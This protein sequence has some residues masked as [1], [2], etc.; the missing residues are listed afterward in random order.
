MATIKD[1]ADKAGVSTA[2]VSR[3]LN[4]DVTLSVSDETK[5][6]VFEV[7]EELSYEKHTIRKR[8]ATKIALINWRTEEEELD[9]IYYMSIRLG[10]EKRCD[11]LNIGIVRFFKNSMEALSKEDIQ[12]MIVIG[13]YSK[14]E[15]AYFKDIT[16]NIVFVDSVVYDEDHFDSVGIDLEKAT[17][18]VVDY[19]LEKNHKDIGYIGGKG[20]YACD[21]RESTFISY[22]KE[23]E[24]LREDY[25]YIGRFLVSDG[26]ELMKKA[27][28][29]H[30]E[31]LPTAFFVA[32]DAIAVGCLN[33]LS[34]AQ[35]QVPD[36]VN[37]IGVND[38]SIS[39]YVSPALSTV[40]VYT[41]LMG[42]TA[43][44]LLI[45][46]FNGRSVSKKVVIATKLKIRQSSF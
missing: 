16:S 4:Y 14:E 5:K 33:A 1:I 37:I 40:K 43:V 19:F 21:I 2:T 36:R 15:V 27:I 29:E 13:C 34:E 24:I 8:R 6:R 28:A 17:K 20:I 30:G 25:V 22:L 3:V 46:N 11:E 26:Y 18:M 23:K 44:D 35:I 31:Q 32:N 45:E 9:D 7:A 41:E 39:Q 10:V 12:G 38:I 42:E